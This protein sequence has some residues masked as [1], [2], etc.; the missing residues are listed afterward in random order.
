MRFIREIVNE[1]QNFPTSN[2]SLIMDIDTNLLPLNVSFENNNNNTNSTNGSSLVSSI[3]S[4]SNKYSFTVDFGWNFIILFALGSVFV[5]FL[6]SIGMWYWCK[7]VN[8]LRRGHS[9]PLAENDF[10]ETTK[11]EAKRLSY[12]PT[13][14]SSI[15]AP[16]PVP[17]R[18]TAYTNILG[19]IEYRSNL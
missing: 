4:S 5:I 8:H 12:S 11:I 9:L 2:T 10:I 6:V 7:R 16:P 18:P 15:Q 14:V 13:K 19:K 3:S 17:P 1:E